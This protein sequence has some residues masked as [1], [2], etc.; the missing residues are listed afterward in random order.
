MNSTQSL[1][2]VVPARSLNCSH[3]ARGRT[4]RPGVIK[5]TKVIDRLGRLTRIIL[6]LSPLPPNK[7]IFVIVFL[8]FEYFVECGFPLV[9]SYEPIG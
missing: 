8:I 6:A 9:E 7:L 4:G 1:K 3:E 2:L 5:Q